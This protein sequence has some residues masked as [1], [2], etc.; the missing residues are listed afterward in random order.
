MLC[1]Y[2]YIESIVIERALIFSTTQEKINNNLSGAANK[3][4]AIRHSDLALRHCL[5]HSPVLGVY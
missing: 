3:V 4:L 1:K 5:R 2:I